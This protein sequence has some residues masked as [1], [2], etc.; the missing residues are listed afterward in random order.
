[1]TSS[2]TDA[3][4]AAASVPADPTRRRLLFGAASVLAGGL[5]LALAAR[6]LSRGKPRP[7]ASQNLFV[8]PE[9]AA[10][11]PPLVPRGGAG[12]RLPR[13]E[14]TEWGSPDPARQAPLM[15][16]HEDARETL[17]SRLPNEV[18]S[19]S[20]R[21]NVIWLGTRLGA[22][23]IETQSDGFT[24]VRMRHFFS[25]DGLPGSGNV[26]AIAADA[27]G[28]A[29]CI[30]RTF[31]VPFG[32]GTAHLCRFE[33]RRNR[34]QTLRRLDLPR[35][36]LY[37][38][39]EA[40]WPYASIV[41]RGVPAVAVTDRR[42]F[43]TLGVLGMPEAGPG[44]ALLVYHKAERVWQDAAW[45]AAT[46]N[47][48]HEAPALPP[49]P[50]AP[51]TPQTWQ[52]F[53]ARL[54]SSPGGFVEGALRPDYPAVNA[55]IAGPTEAGGGGADRVY[56]ATSAGLFRLDIGG[57]RSAGRW[58]RYLS[59]RAFLLAASTP[60]ALYLVGRPLPNNPNTPTE[61]RTPDGGGWQ[62]CRF[63]TRATGRTRDWPLPIA[64]APGPDF[65]VSSDLPRTVP[66][67]VAV[68]SNGA[69]WVTAGR[70]DRDVAFLG[71]R[72]WV[73]D[74]L[75]GRLRTL[76]TGVRYDAPRSFPSEAR[77]WERVP[78]D[79]LLPLVARAAERD[80]GAPFVTQ[81]ALD[82]VRDWL[83]AAPLPGA[84]SRTGWT[85]TNQIEEPA[86]PGGDGRRVTWSVAQR[87][88]QSPAASFLRRDGAGSEQRFAV[89]PLRPEVTAQD[90]E[91][92]AATQN[93]IW[94]TG[95]AYFPSGPNNGRPAEFIARLDR[96]DKTVRLF[97]PAEGLVVENGFLNRLVS[98][99]ETVWA[100]TT[101]SV[102]YLDE[103][104]GR[105]ADLSDVFAPQL[106]GWQSP[107]AHVV[108]AVTDLV[109]DWGNGGS[110]DENAAQG[111][112]GGG[113]PRARFVWALVSGSRLRSIR[114]YFGRTPEPLALAR[115]DV[116]E[117]TWKVFTP[118]PAV[119]PAPLPAGGV[120]AT[121]L[122]VEKDA[123]Y[124]ATNGAGVLRLDRARQT[125]HTLLPPHLPRT[126]MQGG[127]YVARLTRD[128]REPDA[129]YL[130]SQEWVLRW[131]ER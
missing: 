5:S 21:G 17:Y 62:L 26:V 120:R 74:S 64:A 101:E 81:E 15:R 57:A 107:D 110:R 20:R 39:H 12:R 27:D 84:L 88:E 99:G 128:P 87:T 112:A 59:D 18:N 31:E 45:D 80:F 78:D 130:V 91:T 9:P 6:S 44:A 51:S 125:W 43:F 93:A 117:R 7:G 119:L 49:D 76:Q 131:K 8:W 47:S 42:V 61:Q 124:V 106:P 86:R 103:R 72:F 4:A 92:L 60:G 23:R 58:R 95:R 113:P 16:V 104:T 41:G 126:Q 2:R 123:V 100:V 53:D 55:L 14:R 115:Y 97:G 48:D 50:A 37:A 82:R 96:A 73:L 13:I 90:M 52:R 89:P 105:L 79:V 38:A 85:M 30:V 65:Y 19:L 24:P 116:A 94:A 68:T 36:F 114:S 63:D 25:Q 75:T 109:A 118:P 108:P 11:L 29:W 66:Q 102:F 71:T 1:M 54:R 69:V 40:R 22:R 98:D 28:G 10:D 77:L 129:L 32:E 121:W 3:A 111:L 56:L 34:W 33:A 127:G 46:T 70:A 35:T 122:R 67:S 83:P